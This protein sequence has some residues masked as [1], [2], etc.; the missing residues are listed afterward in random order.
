MQAVLRQF[1]DLAEGDL[2]RWIEERWVRPDH[3]PDGYIFHEVDVARVRL[4]VELRNELA[5]DEEA[6]PVVLSL[7]DEVYRLRAHIKALCN[8]IEAQPWE[9]RSALVA[10]LAI[11]AAAGK[12]AE[13][14]P[15]RGET[16]R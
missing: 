15:P 5:I 12:E 9:V 13:V 14:A 16:S 11:G 6:L 10:R 1:R 8:A 7:L 3:D 2:R 4:I